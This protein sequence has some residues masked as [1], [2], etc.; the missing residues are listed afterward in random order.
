MNRSAKDKFS[1]ALASL[2][3]GLNSYRQAH[4][5]AY[6][7]PLAEDHFLGEEWKT[8]AKALLGLLN[9]E[10]GVFDGGQLDGAIRDLAVKAG[11]D[12]DL[13]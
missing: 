9:G 4:A 5:E 1:C 13:E 2:Y 3:D 10:L 6:G 8:M 12:R 7:S 11:F